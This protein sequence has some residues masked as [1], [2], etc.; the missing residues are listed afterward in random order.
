MTVGMLYCLPGAGDRLLNEKEHVS[1]SSETHLEVEQGKPTGEGQ[2]SRMAVDQPQCVSL[3][4][5][6]NKDIALQI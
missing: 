5:P 1:S 4:T 6:V 2:H 3:C